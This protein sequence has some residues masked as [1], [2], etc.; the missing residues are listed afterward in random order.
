[1]GVDVD[2]Q[3][4]RQQQP[5]RVASSISYEKSVHPF[6][7]SGLAFGKLLEWNAR[8]PFRVVALTEAAAKQSNRDVS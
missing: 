5:G 1:L 4:H 8:N 2:A 6:P 7:I 3:Q